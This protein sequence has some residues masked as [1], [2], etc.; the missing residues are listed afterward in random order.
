MYIP[1]YHTNRRPFKNTIGVVI[2]RL[3]GMGLYVSMSGSFHDNIYSV[4]MVTCI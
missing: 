2:N 4:T 3:V 1:V